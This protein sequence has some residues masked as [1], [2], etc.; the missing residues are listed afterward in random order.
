MKLIYKVAGHCFSVVMQDGAMADAFEGLMGNYAPFLLDADAPVQDGTSSLP[1][2][3]FEIFSLQV[4]ADVAPGN[5]AVDTVQEDEGQKIVCGRMS[6]GQSVY[7]FSLGDRP[8]GTLVC[9]PDCRSAILYVN[10]LSPKFALDNSLM[11]MYALSTADK[12]TALFHGAVVSRDNRAYMFLGKSGTGK[13]THARLWLKYVENTELVNDDNPVVRYLPDG[14]WIY[15]SPWSGKTP[16]YRNVAYP[17]GGAV[18][19]SQAP[20]NKIRRL[21][22]IEAYAALVPSISGKRWDKR[23]ADGIHD[24]ENR[25]AM[26]LPMYFLECLPDQAAAE[27]CFK[28]IAGTDGD[29]D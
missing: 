4:C 21:R 29:L 6:T 8:M 27:L 20:Y 7:Q 12:A 14:I 3:L 16:C 22:G 17:L 13:S 18:L 11:I 23:L 28:R 9:L 15:G 19:L 1:G 25:M 2:N 24:M 26:N 10:M 5:F